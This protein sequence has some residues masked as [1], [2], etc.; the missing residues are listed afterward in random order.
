MFSAMAAETA[1][2]RRSID[3]SLIDTGSA[4]APDK[5]THRHTDTPSA[6]HKRRRL[7]DQPRASFGS[8]TK[9]WGG[10]SRC[11]ANGVSLFVSSPSWCCEGLLLSD[12]S[13]SSGPS[14]GP[15]GTSHVVTMVLKSG[16]RW[17]SAAAQRNLCSG[18]G[19]G[20]HTHT[21]AR[22]HFSLM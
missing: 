12:S 8:H 1:H 7:N 11:R 3:A 2:V 6:G 15:V 18:T 9:Q 14:A 4:A 20:I 21:R 16:V 22:T 10:A 19:A 17:Q 13:S 5:Q